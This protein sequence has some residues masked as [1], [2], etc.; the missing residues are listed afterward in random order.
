MPIAQFVRVSKTFGASRAVDDVSLD[1]GRGEFFS[2]LGPSGCGKTTTLRLLA[3]LETP[4]PGGEILIA[5]EPVRN[6]R[7]YERR[8]GMVF[9]SYALFPHLSVE[10]NVAY[11]LERHRVT[12][13]DIPVKVA[14]AL[15]MVRL[16]P[17]EF[18]ARRPAELSGGQ[19]Q[20]VALARALV[21]E[22]EMLL[23]DEPLGAID[24]KLRKTMQLELRQLNRALGITFVYV[25]HD[26]DEALT[27]SDRIA[28][29]D[30]GRIAQLGSP[31][32]IYENPRTA[33]V[34][35]FIG[36]SNLLNGVA[37]TRRNGLWEIATPHGPIRMPDQPGLSAGKAVRIAVRPEWADLFSRD[38]VP[39]GE[40]TLP[41]RVEDVVYQG[42]MLRVRVA[43]ADGATLVV[44]VRNEG[45][46]TRPLDWKPG[47]SV[48]VGWR[49]EDSQLLEDE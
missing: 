1:I 11:G 27:M 13:A 2:L 6:R 16:D 17:G 20:R 23:L 12:R 45:Q 36:E 4:D 22:P 35:T 9:Q 33:F 29:M 41:G 30:R 25:T 42:E 15:E 32:E 48:A 28:V 37:E 39:P 5:G 44:A 10:R 40:N 31:A 46:L 47:D 18:S 24:L 3:G 14:R 26:Q 49:P 38:A 43:L 8:L 21:L 34:A 7:P 19:R